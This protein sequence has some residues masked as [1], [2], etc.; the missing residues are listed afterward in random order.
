[1]LS[2]T[3]GPRHY[4][5]RHPT[6]Q[7][8]ELLDSFLTAQRGPCWGNLSNEV[9]FRVIECDMFIILPAASTSLML[10]NYWKTST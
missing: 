5:G 10:I 2:H 7:T 6:T 3:G 8:L 4:L 1:M 9:I